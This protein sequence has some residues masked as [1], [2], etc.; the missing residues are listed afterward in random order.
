[1]I[2]IDE[3]ALRFRGVQ[4]RNQLWGNSI[5]NIMG[6]RNSNSGNWPI[7][8]STPFNSPD[9]GP[10][11][12]MYFLHGR[13]SDIAQLS[14]EAGSGFVDRIQVTTSAAVPGPR[15]RKF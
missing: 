14:A 12:I 3:L 15:R 8:N 1:L 4:W 6:A 10:D 7:D 9:S 11:N 2:F 13:F 5:T